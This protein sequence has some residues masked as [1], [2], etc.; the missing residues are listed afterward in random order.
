MMKI[1]GIIALSIKRLQLKSGTI[2]VIIKG[3]WI[4]RDHNTDDENIIT[5]TVKY[6]NSSFMVNIL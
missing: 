5:V 6:S 4:G 1:E 2:S 3:L